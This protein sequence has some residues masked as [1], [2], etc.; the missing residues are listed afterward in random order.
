MSNF[1]AKDVPF[2]TTLGNI[3]GRELITVASFNPAIGAVTEEIWSGQKDL[4]YPTAGEAW[5]IVSDN[6]NDTSAGTGAQTV[7]F[8]FMDSNH[9]VIIETLVMN[10]ITPV[11][12]TSTDAFRPMGGMSRTLLGGGFKVKTHGSGKVNAGNIQ[13]N[14]V[15]SAADIKA[16]MVAGD[17][18]G[19]GGHFTVPAGKTA[20]FSYAVSPIRKNKDA[21]LELKSTTGTD[22][23]FFSIFPIENYQSVVELNIPNTIGP[24]VEKSDLKPVA[25]SLNPS[26]EVPLLYQ[27]ILVDN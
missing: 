7:D 6:A 15:G 14:K 12:L 26:T 5:E 11:P 2:E 21:I 13:V 27:L 10:G 24:F 17:N 16:H 8:P 22:G 19:K 25:I 20:Y 23:A 1:G 9:N 3:K 4:T 18:L